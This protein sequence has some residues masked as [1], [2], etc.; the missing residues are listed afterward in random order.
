MIEIERPMTDREIEAAVR[1]MDNDTST[2]TPILPNTV[3][4]KYSRNANTGGG[5]SNGGSVT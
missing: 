5:S 3:R 4:G 2:H 1:R